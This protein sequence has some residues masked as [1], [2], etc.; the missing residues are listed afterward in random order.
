M[1]YDF[2]MASAPKECEMSPENLGLGFCPFNSIYLISAVVVDD[3]LY[4]LAAACDKSEWKVANA[5]LKRV[6]SSFSVN[7]A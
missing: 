1:F 4:V 7:L 3:A 6:R 5:D 2:D